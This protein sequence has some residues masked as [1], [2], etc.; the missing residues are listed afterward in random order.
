MRE[1]RPYRRRVQRG[2]G[3]CSA[4][5]LHLPLQRVLDHGRQAEMQGSRDPG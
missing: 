1:S 5:S 3:R 2:E 4:G